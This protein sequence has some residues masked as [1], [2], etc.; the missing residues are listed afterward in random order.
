M[1]PIY[2]NQEANKDLRQLARLMTQV[3]A[4]TLTLVA[5]RRYL[6]LGR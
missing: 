4:P 2:A 5:S 3:G 6:T 1:G